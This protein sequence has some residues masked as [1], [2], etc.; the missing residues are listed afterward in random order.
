MQ[1][2]SEATLIRQAQQGDHKAFGQLYDDYAERVY[3]YLA[4][5]LHDAMEAEDLTMETFLRAWQHVR[6]YRVEAAPFG[7]WLFRIAHNVWVDHLRRTARR[8]TVP[9]EQAIAI[10]NGAA[11]KAFA[12]TLSRADLE[13]AIA[14]L[15]DLQQQVILLRFV[16]GCSIAETALVMQRS[17][18]AVKDLQHKGLVALRRILGG[19]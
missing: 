15:T 8:A 9:L 13:R 2:P 14:Q 7:A 12:Q 17:E 3:R 4:F 1:V 19:E 18:E 10:A 5:R 16:A 11:A 6:E